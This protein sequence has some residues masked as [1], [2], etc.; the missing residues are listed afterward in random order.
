MFNMR[1]KKRVV[2]ACCTLSCV[3]KVCIEEILFSYLCG[4]CIVVCVITVNVVILSRGF[5]FTKNFKIGSF[6][7][8]DL[9][10]YAFIPL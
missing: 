8:R 3:P 1:F 6:Y 9:D 4:V 2:Y 10:S 7:F 5:R